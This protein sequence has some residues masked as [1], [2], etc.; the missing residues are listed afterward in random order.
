[1]GVSIH[2]KF[3]F[4]Y[5]YYLCRWTT[6]SERCGEQSERKRTR[7]AAFDWG[8]A[9]AIRLGSCRCD[10]RYWRT[11]STLQKRAESRDGTRRLRRLPAPGSPDEAPCR[12]TL[13]SCG[14][15]RERDR[16]ARRR[17][18]A[19][20]TPAW[21]MRAERRLRITPTARIPPARPER[22]SN[23]GAERPRP[24]RGGAV[25]R[26]CSGPPCGG[27]VA[28]G[29]RRP[30]FRVHRGLGACAAE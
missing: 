26:G 23:P 14:V 30:A 13:D 17:P 5:A 3:T 2:Y 22:A 21:R 15:R 25:A 20:D 12:R 7:S 11:L 10:W 6:T 8:V 16:R 9:D 28:P 4:D 27:R 24:P 19:L 1:M 29:L 18:C